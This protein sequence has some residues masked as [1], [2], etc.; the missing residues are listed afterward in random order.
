[1]TVQDT[2]PEDTIRRALDTSFVYE[3]KRAFNGTKRDEAMDALDALVA[4]RDTALRALENLSEDAAQLEAE[5]LRL[6]D[7]ESRLG[8]M[9]LGFGGGHNH[10]EDIRAVLAAS[11]EP[12]E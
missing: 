4:E 5:D 12:R 11:G 10:L 9:L 7:L 3:G 1:M 8:A 2:R 6:H